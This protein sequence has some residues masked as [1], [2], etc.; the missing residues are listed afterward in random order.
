M[1][2]SGKCGKGFRE[3]DW[4]VYNELSVSCEP[5]IWFLKFGS[6]FASSLGVGV[7]GGKKISEYSVKNMIYIF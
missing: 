1:A 2:P 7:G 4:N 3:Q 5:E 6:A